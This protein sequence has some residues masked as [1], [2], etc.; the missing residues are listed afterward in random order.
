MKRLDEILAK[1]GVDG[2]SWS[3]SIVPRPDQAPLVTR[4]IRARD[5][6][7]RLEGHEGL[8]GELSE[9]EAILGLELQGAPTGG[10]N[11]DL[12]DLS[13]EEIVEAKR[14]QLVDLD[15]QLAELQ[16]TRNVLG[17]QVRALE[18]AAGIEPPKK[19]KYRK[20]L[21]GEHVELPTHRD[22]TPTWDGED[23]PIL[24]VVNRDPGKQFVAR[25][26]ANQLGTGDVHAV[27]EGLQR[28]HADGKLVAAERG[29]F[30]AA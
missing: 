1:S 18:K 6:S 16:G 9:I 13:L 26:V 8:A 5:C 29:R 22:M 15:A 2:M 3:L 20:A 28:L 21:P 19:R 24:E 30:Q 10:K 12:T 7:R 17:R 4:N 14:K 23:E 11:M 25:M 27:R